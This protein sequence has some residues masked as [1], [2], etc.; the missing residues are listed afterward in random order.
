M[1]K[2]IVSYSNPPKKNK[3][4]VKKIREILSRWFA[5]KTKTPKS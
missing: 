3:V 1:S 2:F 5:V 4:S